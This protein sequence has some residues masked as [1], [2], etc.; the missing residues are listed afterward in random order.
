[1]KFQQLIKKI[2]QKQLKNNLPIL[3]LGDTICVGVLIQ[4]GNKQRIQTYQGVLIAQHRASRRST[5]TVRRIFQGIGIERIFLLHSPAI[6]FIEVKRCV[7]VRRS[8]LYYLKNMSGKAARLT[9]RIKKNRSLYKVIH[10]LRNY[11]N[12]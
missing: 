12:L 4:E 1:M 7:K 3:S 2:Q 5:I 6:Q 10:R 11:L 9:E 8:K